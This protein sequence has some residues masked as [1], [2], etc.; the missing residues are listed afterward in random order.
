MIDIYIFF[1]DVPH[2]LKTSRNGLANLFGHSMTRKLWFDKEYLS[3]KHIVDLYEANKG[4]KQSVGG[5]LYKLKLKHE[6]VFL[7]P[8]SKMRVDLAAEVL[9]ESVAI[10]LELEGH[11]ESAQFVRFFDKFFDALNVSSIHGG[12]Q[13]RKEYRYPYR[14]GNDHRL[15]W[16]KEDFLGYIAQ[17]EENVSRRSGYSAEEKKKMQLSQQ[18]IEGIK[19]TVQSFIELTKYLFTRSG[20]QF[21]F[22]ERLNQDPLESF[23]G[24]QRQRGGGSDNPNVAQFVSGTSSLRVQGSIALQPLRGNCRRKLFED[25]DLLS[26]TPLP[27]RQR[28]SKF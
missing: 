7:T 14:S 4:R 10:A 15:K 26:D 12:Q 17:W 21:F 28:Q 9:S 22:S 1:S 5:G 11:T 25:E 18:T 13:R 20:V 2:L 19:I 6:H 3:W 16:L 24:K 8:Y 23:F 27:K